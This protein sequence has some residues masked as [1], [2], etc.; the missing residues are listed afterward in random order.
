MSLRKHDFL[1]EDFHPNVKNVAS[2]V[3]L[4]FLD[5]VSGFFG[6][7]VP[8]FFCAEYRISEKVM[9]NLFDI[10]LLGQKLCPCWLCQRK[11]CFLLFFGWMPPPFQHPRLPVVQPLLS[12]S[13]AF[14]LWR[15]WCSSDSSLASPFKTSSSQ[16]CSWGVSC[17]CGASSLWRLPYSGHTCSHAIGSMGLAFKPTFAT[18]VFG[19]KIMFV[20]RAG[21]CARTTNAN[22]IAEKKNIEVQAW[23]LL[24]K[25]L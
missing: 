19:N 16:I 5:F 4:W 2:S 3:R 13:T 15:R 21:F 12:T 7:A 25:K 10:I 6:E 20:I 11:K 14:S 22:Q 24:R 23:R 1:F 18:P 17:R 9:T 8:F